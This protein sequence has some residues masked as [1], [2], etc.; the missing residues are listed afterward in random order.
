MAIGSTQKGRVHHT[1]AVYLDGDWLIEAAKLDDVVNETEESQLWFGEVDEKATTLWAKFKNL[2]PNE[3]LTEINVRKTVFY[4]EK[5]DINYITV[6][7]FTLRH[8]ATQWAP[9]T[10]EQA[11][12]IGTHWS[13][14]WII[15]D[16]N[17]SYSV[18]SGISLGKY[19]DQWDNTSRIPHKDT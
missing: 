5:T 8:A 6:K 19:G 13:K 4:P 12:L 9:P 2:D 17:V 7:G 15:E 18:C 3:Q 10:A 16:N 1:G 14:G 11:G